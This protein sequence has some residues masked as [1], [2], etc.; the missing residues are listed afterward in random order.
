MLEA[1]AWDGERDKGVAETIIGSS[2][3]MFAGISS[4]QVGQ[5]LK[6]TVI[7]MNRNDMSILKG[8]VGRRL[9]CTIFGPT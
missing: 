2:V 3:L 9:A 6:R 4:A 8:E 7:P 1:G 5:K